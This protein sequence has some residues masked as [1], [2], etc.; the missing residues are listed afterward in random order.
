MPSLRHLLKY[1]RFLY[2]AFKLSFATNRG[3]ATPRQL[4]VVNGSMMDLAPAAV[5]F[6]EHTA[7][8]NRQLQLTR[9][10]PEKA[11]L[12]ADGVKYFS[13]LMSCIFLPSKSSCPLTYSSCR[14]D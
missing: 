1:G 12:A 13:G 10:C 2:R 11:S 3:L 7:R 4:R 8:A 9:S 5:G 14:R 6:L